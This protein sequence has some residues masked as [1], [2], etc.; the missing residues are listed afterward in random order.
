MHKLGKEKTQ[1]YYVYFRTYCTQGTSCVPWLSCSK[2]LKEQEA[3]FYK[4]TPDSF[5]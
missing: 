2:V 3:D 1:S 4:S 5:L